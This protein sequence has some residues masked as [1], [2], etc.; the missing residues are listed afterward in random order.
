MKW[1][2]LTTTFKLIV[3]GLLIVALLAVLSMGYNFYADRF[4]PPASQSNYIGQPEIKK[5]QKI[6]HKKIIVAS[7]IDVLDKEEAVKKLKI[8]DP[9]KSDPNKQITTTAEIKPYDGKTSIVSVLDTST[10]E[11][12]IIAQQEELSL[13]EFENKREWEIKAGPSTEG[14]IKVTLNIKQNFLR[15]KKVH[16]GGFV[17]GGGQFFDNSKTVNDPFVWGG[18]VLGG[19]SN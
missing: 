7:R 10:G 5:A 9:V 17:E 13:F 15:V 18:I 1:S 16:I 14:G 12:E 8:N 3:S 11:S 4:K 19:T 6:E 2:D